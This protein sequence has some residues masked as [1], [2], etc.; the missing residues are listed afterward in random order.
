MDAET[1][2]AQYFCRRPRGSLKL[3]AGVLDVFKQFR[4]VDRYATEAGGVIIGRHIVGTDD[5]VADIATTP[6]ASDRRTRTK[7]HR[8]QQ[9]HQQILDA[10]WLRSAGTQVYLGEWH[11]HPEPFPSPSS[12]DMDDWRRRL[13]RDAVEAPFV[14]FLIVGQLA[15]HVWEGSRTAYGVVRLVPQ[16]F[17]CPDGGLDE[18]A[19][20]DPDFSSDT[21]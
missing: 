6:S 19:R 7:F 16:K 8:S 17:T 20:C 14:F 2:Q 1:A 9:A 21:R 12:V 3:D 11:T 15:I 13:E 4:Q 10:V 5:V 18:R